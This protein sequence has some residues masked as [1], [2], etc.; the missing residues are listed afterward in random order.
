MEKFII[1][2]GVPLAGTIVPAGNKNGALPILAACLLTEE[3]V[4]LEN[5]PRISDVETMMELIEMLGARIE[6][7]G[8]NSVCVDASSVTHA[9]VDR[10]LSERIRASFLLAGPL[11]ARFGRAHMPPPGGDVIGRRR[12]DP[13][14]DAF[15]EFGATVDHARDLVIEAPYGLRPC[16]FLMDEPSVMATENALMIAA[17]TPGATVIRNAAS[18]PHVQ[19]LAR[20]LEC[21]GARIDGVGSN[22]M[23]VHGVSSLGGGAHRIAPDHIEIGSFMALAGVTGGELVV[24]DTMPQDLRMIRIVFERLGLHSELRGNDVIVPGAQKLVIRDDAGGLQPKV[25]SGPWPAFP[26]DLT[27]VALALATQSEGSVLIHEK[28]FENRLFFADKLERMGARILVC[29]PHR[30]VVV[31]PRRL[32]GERV[33]SPDIRAGMAILMAAL[34]ADGET[35]IGNIGQIDRGYERID[36]RLRE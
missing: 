27:S 13:H 31:G 28:M 5:V 12:L 10:G 8:P 30:A 36:E 1:N 7:R 19:D 11:L 15:K 20:M 32:R 24:K 17:L 33:E 23:T 3:E 4:V 9:E 26:A 16:D 2:G 18:E 25:D 21:M 29:D 6:W 22:V 35:E 14:L 34:C